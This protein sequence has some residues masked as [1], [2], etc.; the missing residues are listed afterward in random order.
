MAEDLLKKV[1]GHFEELKGK[2]TQA[3]DH[4]VKGGMQVLKG[5]MENANADT[6]IALQ[7]ANEHIKKDIEKTKEKISKEIKQTFD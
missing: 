1:E 3:S 5:K 6:D 2:L 7:D 4:H